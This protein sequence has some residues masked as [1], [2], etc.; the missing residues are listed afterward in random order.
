MSIIAAEVTNLLCIRLIL[1]VLTSGVAKQTAND[2]QKLATKHPRERKDKGPRNLKP[3][4]VYHGC[5]ELNSLRTTAFDES[6]ANFCPL[7]F[8]QVEQLLL[9]YADSP[10]LAIFG[11]AC[12]GVILPLSLLASFLNLDAPVHVLN[13]FWQ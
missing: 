10:L 6:V 4:H 12:A 3:R 1:A 11:E 5:T 7:R 2:K 13:K 8:S 9:L